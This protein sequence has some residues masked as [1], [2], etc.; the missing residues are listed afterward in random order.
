MQP[1]DGNENPWQRPDAEPSDATPHP[2]QPPSMFG[3]PQPP[4]GQP[5]PPPSPYGPPPSY[6]QAPSYGQ[7][8]YDQPT[9]DQPTYGSS[10]HAAPPYG[11]PPQ[12]YGQSPYGPPP[13]EYGQSPYGQPPQ[14]GQ[15]PYGQPPQYG[16]PSPQCGMYQPSPTPVRKKRGK[17]LGLLAAVIAVVVVIGGIAYAVTQ[18][19]SHKLSHSAVEKT[20]ESQS[21]DTSK[22]FRVIT[23][24]NCN[25]GK[26]ITVKKD[27]SFTCTA[28]GNVR[29][30]VVIRSAAR[31]PAWAWAID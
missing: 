15:S 29:I 22:S 2:G 31:N 3:P 17:A 10:P 1:R 25:G 23:D 5:A 9:Y 19:G 28:A 21:T 26:D 27:A 6:G 24:V 12:Q 8:T 14:Y 18:L 30:T 7:P 13:Q 4:Y 20:I 16:Q 11:P